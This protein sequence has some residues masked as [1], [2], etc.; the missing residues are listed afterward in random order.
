[1]LIDVHTHISDLYS[2]VK[3]L[4]AHDFLKDNVP[5]H[6]FF[7]TGVHPWFADFEIIDRFIRKVKKHQQD[8]LIAIGECGLDRVKGPGLSLQKTIFEKQLSLASELQ[9]PVIIHQVKTISD[10][11]PFLKKYTSLTYVFH[12]YN[13]N[14]IQTRQLLD[15]NAS[16]SFG[17]S[18]LKMPEKLKKSLDIIPLDKIF[19]ETD[20]AHL[21]INI[22]FEKMASNKDLYL[23]DLNLK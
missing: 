15:F 4:H 7:T 3:S 1:M 18:M 2:A 12:A 19:I 16:F 11:I 8:N 23:E 14:E 20:E 22:L 5:T 10:I 17:A 9:L 21:A 6:Q 13:G